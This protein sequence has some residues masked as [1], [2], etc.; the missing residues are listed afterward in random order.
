VSGG[1]ILIAK[2]MKQIVFVAIVM[3][4]IISVFAAIQ[5]QGLFVKNIL[6]LA[7]G[8]L[9]LFVIWKY[10]FIIMLKDYERAVIFR[11]GKVSRVGGP[12]WCLVVPVI[13]SYS[14]VD[15]RVITLDVPKQD[16]ITKDNIL[17]KIDAVI[18]IRVGKDPQSVINSVVKVKDYK[19]ATVLYVIAKTRDIIGSMNFEESISK[20]EF[21]NEELR[22]GLEEISKEWGIKCDSVEIKDIDVPEEVMGAMHREKVAVQEKLA[23]MERAKAH[24]AEIDAVRDAAEG[25]SDK[26]VA[27]YYIK[28]LEELGR[29]K[30]TKFVFPMELSKLASFVT[31]KGGAEAHSPEVEELFRKYA[32][33]V[34]ALVEGKATKPVQKRKK[35]AKRKPA[36]RKPTKKK[37]GR[38]KRAGKKKS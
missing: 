15:L 7:L 14:V 35:S 10:D 8:T 38:A 36:K 22:K 5:Y 20:V 1:V 34:K 12:G 4:L 19:K 2:E 9:F 6:W 25:L 30:S 29:G 24:M 33:A 31:S 13:E 28:A 11:F 17:L 21:L 37:Q 3:L 18:Y 26:A 16:V 23:R 27:Y 32:P